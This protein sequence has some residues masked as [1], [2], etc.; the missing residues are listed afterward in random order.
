[1]NH[2]GFAGFFCTLALVVLL[3]EILFLEK[4]KLPNSFFVFYGMGCI[5]WVFLALISDQVGL[6]LISVIQLLFCLL[7]YQFNRES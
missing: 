2:S 5:G 4:K 3:A 1:M 6:L 7:S